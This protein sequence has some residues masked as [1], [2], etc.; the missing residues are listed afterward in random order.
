MRKLGRF[1]TLALALTLSFALAMPA[2]AANETKTVV[3]TYRGVQV[4]VDGETIVPT[5]AAGNAVE[6]FILSGT[7][8]LPLRAV[9]GALGL[10]VAWDEASSTVTLTSGGLKKS[11]GEDALS[12]IRTVN[13]NIAY[14]DIKLVVDG[15][16]VVPRD[17]AGNLVEPFIYYGTTY[18]PI[19]AIA[20]ALGV[21]VGWESDSATA[22][23]GSA[24]AKTVWVC[25]SKT[26]IYDPEIPAHND[27]YTFDY[28]SRARLIYKNMNGAE[29]G[30]SYDAAGRISVVTMG[31]QSVEQY[32]YDA[33]GRVLTI[34]S[35]GRVHTRNTYDANG[36]LTY[37]TYG[38]NETYYTYNSAGQRTS[39]RNNSGVGEKYTYDAFGR[40]LT[41]VH[42]E[43]GDSYTD[44]FTYDAAGHRTYWSRTGSNPFS[45]AYT[46]D[47]RG[48]LVREIQKGTFGPG[49][50]LSNSYHREYDAQGRC[51]FYS[52]RGFFSDG[53][54]TD[55]SGDIVYTYD[56]AGRLVKQ[57]ST[58]YLLDPTGYVPST[59]T[60]TYDAAGNLLEEDN[61]Q[62]DEFWNKYVYT[63][64]A[65][66]LP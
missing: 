30:Y 25:T 38:T 2:A 50:E 48:D 64:R 42:S 10:T 51:T 22:W 59:T 29:W 17:A 55:S 52:E 61:Y 43:V 26:F 24:P 56:A 3:L 40:P 16:T 41:V 62:G 7:T 14:R 35:G 39:M 34:A 12:T 60:Y 9:A 11:G 44:T 5:D 53:D 37:F 45:I 49:V 23:L 58:R 21:E 13:A 46:Y 47:D 19:R 27:L 18:L 57:V 1:L 65:I 66:D 63:Y 6:P 54:I 33:A 4:A 20:S 36:N 28:D 15:V 31:G 8:Y 32:T